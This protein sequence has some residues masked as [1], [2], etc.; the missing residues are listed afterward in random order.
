[1]LLGESH[2]DPA[3]MILILEGEE[4]REHKIVNTGKK[5]GTA[6]CEFILPTF[7]VPWTIAH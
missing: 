1:M 3:F 5:D 6:A 4:E 7:C 2:R